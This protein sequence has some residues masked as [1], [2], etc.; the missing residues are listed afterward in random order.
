MYPFSSSYP[1]HNVQDIRDEYDYIIIGGGTAGCVLAKR[2]TSDATSVLLVERGGVGDSWLSYIPLFS[3]PFNSNDDRTTAL[4]SIPQK[5]VGNR[6]FDIMGGNSLGGGTKINAMLYTRGLPAEY[7]RW[8]K[9]GRVGW[10]YDDLQKYF[11]RS[12]TDLDQNVNH[13]DD[14]HGLKGEWQNRSHPNEYWS[15]TSYITQATTNLGI[16]YVDDLNSPLHPPQGCAKMHYNIDSRGYRSSTFTAFLPPNFVNKYKERLHLCTY[17]AVSEIKFMEHEG[18]IEA[19]GVNLLSTKEGSDAGGPVRYV[20]ARR[21]IIVSAGAISSPQILMF[22]GVGPAQHLKQ[23]GI[24]VVKDLPAVG[25]HLQDHVAV[26]LQFRVPLRDSVVKLSAQPWTIIKEF[27]L[28]IFFGTGL[29]LAPMLELS[30]FLQ[31]QLFNKDF[32]K[33]K[34][35]LKE[36]DARLPENIP[37]IE[38]MPIA[39]GEPTTLR[40]YGSG[41]LTFFVV[42]LQ[43]NSLG[44]VTLSSRDPFSN[45]VV[46]LNFFE[47]EHDWNII[48]QGVK[49]GLKIQQEMSALTYPIAAHHVPESESDADVEAFIQEHCRTT[50]HYSS[51]CRMA[52]EYDGDGIGGVVDDRLR[53]HGICRLRIADASIFPQILSTHL[54][55]PV[56]AV[57]EKCADMIKEDNF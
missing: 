15:H 9:D 8:A 49:L 54:A 31:I 36:Q 12:E 35:T 16:P 17:T 18:K 14:F 32:S 41:G 21:E 22:S 56:V 2:L 50:T 48:R 28:Y 13:P 40:P 45:P 55:A 10:G 39:F 4:Q 52:P 5:Y 43:P 23:H 19:Q 20:K 26:P 44:S 53:V 24:T 37:D 27:L 1:T 30:I 33:M 7:N 25:K 46:D 57:A 34:A 42:N 11:C 47:T 3:Q 51:T 29:L 38:I 6:Q